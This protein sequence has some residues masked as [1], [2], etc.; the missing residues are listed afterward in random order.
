MWQEFTE[1]HLSR[2]QN[3]DAEVDLQPW[4]SRDVVPSRTIGLDL[5]TYEFPN[6]PRPSGEV[7]TYPRI[8]VDG[9]TAELT[10]CMIYRVTGEGPD[11]TDAG[12]D[13]SRNWE[14]T[15]KRNPER[16]WIIT[17]ISAAGKSDTNCVPPQL[18]RRILKAYD[19]FVHARDRWWNPIDPNHPDLPDYVT[20]THL[21]RLQNEI[22]PPQVQANA[23]G[24][25]DR[26]DTSNARVADVGLSTATVEECTESDP[27]VG[28]F[29]ASTGE[30]LIEAIDDDPDTNTFYVTE[31]VSGDDGHWRVD[32]NGGGLNVPCKIGE[33]Q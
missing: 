20:A 3:P 29:D 32:A 9:D 31:M 7:Q 13:K 2:H 22:M 1:T 23:I 33:I 12:S 28:L 11:G 30:R 5:P 14:A 18:R 16:G 21:A 24:R 8:T 4:L 15:L 19:E 6:S 17:A 25:F 27:D 10:D 26:A